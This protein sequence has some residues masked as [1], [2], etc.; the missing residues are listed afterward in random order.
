MKE[1]IKEVLQVEE[2]VKTILDQARK[3]ADE[4]KKTADRDMSEKINQAKQE[5]RNIYATTVDQAKKQAGHLANEKLKQADMEKENMIKSNEVKM[6]HLVEDICKEIL[7]PE[8]DIQN[9]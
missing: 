3:E 5:T 7:T 4:I 6:N 9:K 2:Q 1:V 8:Y